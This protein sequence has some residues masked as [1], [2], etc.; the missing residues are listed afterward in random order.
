MWWCVTGCAVPSV[1]KEH[2]AVITAAQQ[3][4]QN[5]SSWTARSQR[6]RQHNPFKSWKQHTQGHS[7]RTESLRAPLSEP[8]RSFIT[9]EGLS[10]PTFLQSSYMMKMWQ[11][12][13]P[14]TYGCR[15]LKE[16]SNTG[17]C[18]SSHHA[19]RNMLIIM[20]TLWKSTKT[21]SVLVQVM[22]YKHIHYSQYSPHIW[23]WK[24]FWKI[25]I[26]VFEI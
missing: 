11:S 3:S 26:K 10:L 22:Y 17:A 18:F 16:T 24:I 7:V 4:K 6:L 21:L 25:N 2:K 12:R 8:Q 23:S 19:G 15:M 13:M 20:G 1:S 5:R 14:C 9:S